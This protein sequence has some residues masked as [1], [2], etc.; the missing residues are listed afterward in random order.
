MR[1]MML[2]QMR[3]PYDSLDC[4]LLQRHRTIDTLVSLLQI[5]VPVVTLLSWSHPSLQPRQRR[6]EAEMPSSEGSL[7]LAY[8][9]AGWRTG[10]TGWGRS[11]GI[12]S[13]YLDTCT[14]ST[15]RCRL[16][17]RDYITGVGTGQVSRY[18]QRYLGQEHSKCQASRMFCLSTVRCRVRRLYLQYTCSLVAVNL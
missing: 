13:K 9:R 6:L 12:L 14:C 2:V 3:W 10:C 1:M 17:Y 18:L 15:G 7:H 11:P 5:Q 4:L 8:R 16:D